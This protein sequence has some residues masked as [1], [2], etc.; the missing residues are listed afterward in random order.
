MEVKN[1]AVC[2]HT[3]AVYMV[4]GIVFCFSPNTCNGKVKQK[5]GDAHSSYNSVA[6]LTVFRA[7]KDAKTGEQS[8][9]RFCC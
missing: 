5:G 7:S 2:V 6:K 3:Q 9:M 1:G 8:L 4:Y